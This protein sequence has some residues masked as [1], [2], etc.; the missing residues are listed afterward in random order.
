VTWRAIIGDRVRARNLIILLAIAAIGAPAQ[1]RGALA[2]YA[3]TPCASVGDASVVAVVGATCEDAVAVAARVVAQPID[4]EGEALSAAGWT[5]VRTQSTRDG[6]AHDL[7]AMRGDGA[8]LRVRRGGS[9][10][11]LDGWEAGRALIFAP[12]TLVGGA[13]IPDRSEGCTSSWLVLLKGDR[14]GGLSAGHCGGLRSDHTVKRPN[15]GL[16]RA[17]GSVGSWSGTSLGTVTRSLL[18]ATS[19]KPIDALVVP[20]ASAANLT[21]LPLIDRGVSLP[22]WRVV[23]IARPTPGRRVCFSGAT[24]GI[25]RCGGIF[26]GQPAHLVERYISALG[27]AVRCTTVRADQGDSG[28]PV[29]TRPTASGKVYA[30]GITTL[31]LPPLGN[32]MCFTPLSPVLRALGARL[33]IL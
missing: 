29:Y 9:A 8:A 2:N 19:R 25:D 22:P 11:D 15:A 20:V 24:S 1:A 23:G 5:P 18:H 7:L 27:T 13:P 4:S 3:Y 10:P 12:G 32:A 33:A 14:L 30:I 28:G 21:A 26:A 17:P 6:G 16:L 31:V